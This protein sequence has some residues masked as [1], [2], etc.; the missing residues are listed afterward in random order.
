MRMRDKPPAGERAYY[1]QYEECGFV[2]GNDK[3]E[4]ARPEV[5]LFLPW[6]PV[7][8]RALDLGC[9]DG[10]VARRIMDV[11]Q[12]RVS[13]LE[14]DPQGVEGA[15][16]RGVDA[17]V[18]DLD[19]GLPF[20]NDSFDVA[21]ANVT[22]HMV[23]RPR[24]LLEEALRV[25]PRV[26]VTFPNFGFWLYRAEL[27]LRGRFPKHSL[28]GYKWYDTRHIHLFSLA[29]LRDLCRTLGARIAAE[30]FTGMRNRRESRLAGMAPNLLARIVAVDIRRDA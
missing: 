24:Y 17:L 23:Y 25:A 5:E 16:R 29:D 10:A 6:I 9:G 21:V 8:S 20:G 28:Y 30:R 1:R 11:R 4:R 27:T 15:I 13:G 26:I 3:K 14:I 18:G 12:A 7:G 22:L 2:Y 19:E